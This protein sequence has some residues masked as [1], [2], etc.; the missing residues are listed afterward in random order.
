MKEAKTAAAADKGNAELKVAV[1]AEV[2][3][4]LQLKAQLPELEKAARQVGGIPR[5]EKGAVDYQGDF[6]GRPAFLTVS[7][8]LNAEY[9][10]C[11]LS[12]VYTFGP[13]FRAEK[14]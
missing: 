2:D 5:T 9:Y 4:L 3:K 8:Q 11:A 1:K 13:T 10:A 14:S 7:G 6:F 12:N